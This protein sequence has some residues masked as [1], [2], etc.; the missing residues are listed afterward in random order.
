M[1]CCVHVATL[2]YYLSYAKNRE[3][4]IP[5]EQLND[6]FVNIHNLEASN[7][8]K[9][10]RRKRGLKETSSSSDE[11]TDTESTEYQKSSLN[12]TD[13]SVE[14]EL[15][16]E[17]SDFELMDKNE[18]NTI[19]ES[20]DFSGFSRQNNIINLNEFNRH[21][22]QWSAVIKY[23]NIE[24]VYV[25]DTCTID[26]YL[27]ALWALSLMDKSFL[28]NI[29]NIEHSDELKN[30]VSNINMLKW[31]EAKQ[32]FIV[33]V[34]KLKT[35]IVRKNISLF[36][37]EYNFIFFP[38][39][40][41]QIHDVFQE[42]TESCS[43]N[44]IRLSFEVGNTSIMLRKKDKSKEKVFWYSAD[45]EKCRMCKTQ[46]KNELRFRNNPNFL[47]IENDLKS[48]ICSHELPKI[49]SFNQNLR[50]RFFCSTI[51][52]RDISHF[53]GVYEINHSLYLIDDLKK[54]CV[55]F[56]EENEFYDLNISF[57]LYYL[58]QNK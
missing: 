55:L 10:I 26:Y 18:A 23:Q 50:F 6:I 27:F 3:K 40:M 21:I 25:T 33:E 19:A 24:D 5:G 35:K 38:F 20:L 43:Q 2:I 13:R 29:P 57:S 39:R 53:L 44:G 46:I 12:V 15:I 41:F 58:I 45:V 14:D 22:P 51:F 30:I 56:T 28:N 52:K 54:N 17:E 11:D 1:G 49:I 36:G 9:Y 48:R 42:C 34:L 32:S 31:N 4:R 37:S 7:Q 8:P 47:F 16:S